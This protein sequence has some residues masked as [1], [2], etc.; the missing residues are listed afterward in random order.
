MREDV[1]LVR[2]E[3]EAFENIVCGFELEMKGERSMT[4]GASFE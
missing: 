1:R 4:G 2:V 3:G